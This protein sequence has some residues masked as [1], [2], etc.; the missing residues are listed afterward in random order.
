MF[1]GVSKLSPCKATGHHRISPK[2]LKDS[3][4]VID[5]SQTKIFNQSLLNVVFPDD[6]KIAII[7][8]ILK[9]ESKLECNNYRP[10]PVLSA[11]S[12]VFKKLV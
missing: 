2:L 12:K 8:Q 4:R 10:I 7:S 11:I 3:A 5:S 9:S 1:E 6:F